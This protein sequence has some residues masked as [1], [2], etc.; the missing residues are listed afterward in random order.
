[1]IVWVNFVFY[2]EGN[3]S[4][5]FK[6]MSAFFLVLLR[7]RQLEISPGYLY[8]RSNSHDD[9]KNYRIFKKKNR[10]K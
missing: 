8:V 5:F 7:G 3:F 9:G 4:E 10:L 1:M 2:S 6:S